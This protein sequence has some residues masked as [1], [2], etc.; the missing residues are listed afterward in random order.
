VNQWWVKKKT[1]AQLSTKMP[2][3][4]HEGIIMWKLKH[5][6]RKVTKKKSSV[7]YIYIERERTQICDAKKRP[8]FYN[9][10]A[11]ACVHQKYWHCPLYVLYVVPFIVYICRIILVRTYVDL[12]N[13]SKKVMEKKLRN[14]MLLIYIYWEPHRSRVVFVRTSLCFLVFSSF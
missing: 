3:C 2:S 6:R 1:T 7:I 10:L 9:I 5:S 14:K 8:R 12:D 13:S 11:L 4:I